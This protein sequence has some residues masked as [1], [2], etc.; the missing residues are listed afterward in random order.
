MLYFEKHGEYSRDHRTQSVG[1]RIFIRIREEVDDGPNPYA[2]VTAVVPP[3]EGQTGWQ[4]S[5]N[6]FE[7]PS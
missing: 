5:P 4:R 7:A 2:Q 6:P 1:K 3:P